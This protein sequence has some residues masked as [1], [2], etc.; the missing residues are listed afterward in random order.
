MRLLRIPPATFSRSRAA[1]LFAHFPRT[2]GS[3]Y[4]TSLREELLRFILR[5]YA[6]IEAKS[7]MRRE[8]KLL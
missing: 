6:R 3:T 1:R 5:H 8:R 2:D 4:I 7:E